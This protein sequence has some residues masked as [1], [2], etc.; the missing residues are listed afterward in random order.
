VLVFGVIAHSGDVHGY[1]RFVADDPGVV[2]GRDVADI[3][4]TELHFGA[5]VHADVQ[6]ARNVILQV[7]R[8]AAMGLC[9]R[10]DARGPTPAGLERRA[11]E[12]DVVDGYE[13]NLALLERA[14]SSGRARFFFSILSIVAFII[15]SITTT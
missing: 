9:Q 8:L 11:P 6:P 4:R 10:F 5:I 15:F 14:V 12:G 2:A 13:F 7:G 1:D 3:P